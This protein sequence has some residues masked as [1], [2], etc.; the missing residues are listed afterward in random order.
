MKQSES[1]NVSD[2]AKYLADQMMLRMEQAVQ[3]YDNDE[4]NM[5]AFIYGELYD[6]TEGFESYGG[7]SSYLKDIVYPKVKN[8]YYKRIKE[9]AD[10]FMGSRRVHSKRKTTRSTD[11]E[12]RLR[13][14]FNFLKYPIDQTADF[15]TVFVNTLAGDKTEEVIDDEIINETDVDKKEDLLIQKLYPPAGSQRIKKFFDDEIHLGKNYE[16]VYQ[17]L[18]KSPRLKGLS[19]CESQ[20]EICEELYKNIRQ[21]IRKSGLTEIR[22]Y[23]R[24][25]ENEKDI[26]RK[27]YANVLQ[28]KSMNSYDEEAFNEILMREEVEWEDLSPLED[29][30]KYC[31]LWDISIWAITEGF[32][33]CLLHNKEMIEDKWVSTCVNNLKALQENIFQAGKNVIIG[34]D[35]D[36]IYEG[37][38]LYINKQIK[39]NYFINEQTIWDEYMRPRLEVETVDNERVEKRNVVPKVDFTKS[40][41]KEEMERLMMYIHKD[42]PEC[43]ERTFKSRLKMCLEFIKIYGM[44]QKRNWNLENPNVELVI[45][46]YQ[47]FYIDKIK[48]KRR[49]ALA[50][51]KDFMQLLESKYEKDEL[52]DGERQT[53]LGLLQEAHYV[54]GTLISIKLMEIQPNGEKINFVKYRIWSIV[55]QIAVQTFLAFC[56]GIDGNDYSDSFNKTR[57][58]FEKIYKEIYN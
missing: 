46:L 17:I 1:T 31:I 43:S 28:E 36:D 12:V 56:P 58:I 45:C 55:N 11:E 49:E 52:N 16:F 24:E 38:Y 48:Y 41:T 6:L 30:N 9:L 8:V 32:Q 2:L 27:K 10:S 22:K 14:S 20:T 25:T 34:E 47:I 44:D 33:Q 39:Y 15:F 29:F 13:P 42:V 26:A 51:A 50:W 40:L 19:L 35:T 7:Y 21:D 5:Y 4:D 23:P 57:D 53:K 18:G 3:D 54:L 37:Y